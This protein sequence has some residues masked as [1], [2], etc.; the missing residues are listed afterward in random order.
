[1]TETAQSVSELNVFQSMPW[2]AIWL[3]SVCVFFCDFSTTHLPT[4]SLVR[5]YFISSCQLWH[6]PSWQWLHFQWITVWHARTDAPLSV[7]IQLRSTWANRPFDTAVIDW[8]PAGPLFVLPSRWQVLISPKL[9]TLPTT[10]RQTPCYTPSPA[11]LLHLCDADFG[12]GGA[13]QTGETAN[14]RQANR[15]T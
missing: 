6:D 5:Q 11:C 12:T 10:P 13:S 1:M 3:L 8:R 14:L 7:W 4:H 9:L 15:Q 2:R